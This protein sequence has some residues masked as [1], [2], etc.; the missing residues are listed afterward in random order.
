MQ[1]AQRRW[2]AANRDLDSAVYADDANEARIKELVKEAQ[3][4]QAELLKERTLTEYLI[5]G[6]LTPEQLVKFRGLRQQLKQDR[7][8]DRKNRRDQ[9]IQNQ[10]QKQFNRFEQRRI[11]NRAQ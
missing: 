6:V 4:A 7:F 5:R 1:D 11:Q 10:P 3:L 9:N 8:E 2:R